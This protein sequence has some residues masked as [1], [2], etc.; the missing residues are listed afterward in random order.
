MTLT[1]AE[2]RDIPSAVKDRALREG[3]IAIAQSGRK[4]FKKNGMSYQIKGSKRLHRN[5][6]GKS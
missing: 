3:S 4:W 6:K 2:R 1:K 5:L